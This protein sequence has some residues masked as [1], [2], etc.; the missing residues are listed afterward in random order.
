MKWLYKLDYK[1]GKTY[2]P[3]L[4]TIIVAGMGIVY[5]AQLM[6]PDVPVYQTLSLSRAGLLGW[7][8]WRLVTFLFV[9]P[10]G[11]SLVMLI[12]LYFYYFMGRSL[13]N[14]W[15]GFR[16]NLYY[17][18]G[19]LGA[20]VACLITGYGDNTYLN[21]S[22][23]LAFATLAPDTTFMLFFIL[24]LKAKW[25]AIAYAAFM[26]F[27]L[28]NNFFRSSSLGLIALV[29]LLFSLANYALF[30]GR[31]LFDS[32]RNQIRVAKNRRNWRNR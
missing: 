32:I 29:S 7:Q 16:L 27:S 30:F 15:G 28:L 10:S 2:I 6:M 3:N 5:V 21:L 13:E 25:L 11:S 9:P 23:F 17:L 8:L 20:I 18:I 31:D 19:V 1:Y 22:L 4:M 12:S 14:I 26:A 24:P